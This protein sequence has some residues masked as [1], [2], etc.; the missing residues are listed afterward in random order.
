MGDQK[1][2]RRAAGRPLQRRGGEGVEDPPAVGTAVVEDRVA[3]AAVDV[4]SRA[5]VA[6]GA[7]ESVGVKDLEEPLGA[8]VLVH[9]D[10]QLD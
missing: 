10:T 7:S 2:L 6:A 8:G 3:S 1:D 9:Q 5:G 4:V